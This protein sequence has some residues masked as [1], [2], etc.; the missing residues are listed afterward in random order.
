L[1]HPLPKS[2]FASSHSAVCFRIF[3]VFLKQP[4]LLCCPIKLQNE[5]E[6]SNN[7]SRTIFLMSS[8]L[9]YNLYPRNLRPV[10]RHYPDICLEVQR[11]PVKLYCQDIWYM[12]EFQAEV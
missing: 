6:V 12:A 7:T 9:P 3:A 10:S 2:D 4:F 1:N 5:T 11:I 8:T